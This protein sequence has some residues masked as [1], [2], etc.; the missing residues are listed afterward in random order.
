MAEPE[1]I[2]E[3]AASVLGKLV[4][5][6]RTERKLVLFTLG[7]IVITIIVGTLLYVATEENPTEGAI[8]ALTTLAGTG[9]GFIGG[10]VTKSS[11]EDGG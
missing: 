4:K 7:I 11:L 5:P 10:M 6:A 9:L 2:E 1:T 8:T 3:P